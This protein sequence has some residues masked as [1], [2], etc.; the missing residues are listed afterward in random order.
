MNDLQRPSYLFNGVLR[1]ICRERIPRP[2]NEGK[3]CEGGYYRTAEGYSISEVH[4]K[5]G[6]F[7][8]DTRDRQ[9]WS[10]SKTWYTKDR[11]SVVEPSRRVQEVFA[12]WHNPPRPFWCKTRRQTIKI[13][14][15]S[16]EIVLI[17][18]MPD[19][20]FTEN[21]SP[22]LHGR[23]QHRRKGQTC[24]ATLSN[25]HDRFRARAP[26]ENRTRGRSPGDTLCTSSADES[27]YAAIYS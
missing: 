23:W 24:K 16:T 21:A 8:D 2:K 11:E 22:R 6:R 13:G 27:R 12:R 17:F 9:F 4:A 19:M 1:K 26:A 3:M 5:N 15:F 7:L 10:R 25:P 14:F 18:T 20:G